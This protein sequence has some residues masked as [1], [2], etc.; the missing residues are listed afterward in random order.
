MKPLRRLAPTLLAA[1]PLLA[2]AAPP[3]A[4]TTAPPARVAALLARPEQVQ[5][6]PVPAGTPPVRFVT[7]RDANPESPSQGLELCALQVPPGA[8]GFE[9]ESVRQEGR[10]TE[11]FAQRARPG[12][13]GLINGGFFGVDRQGALMPLGLLKADGRVLQRR[14]PWAS[15]GVLHDGAG[16][17]AISPVARF[18]DSPG[19]RHAIQSK[20]ML[21]Q[22]GGDGIRQGAPERFDRSAVAITDRGALWLLVAHEP[23]GR[24]LSLNEFS[25][26]LLRL[27]G[28]GGERIVDALAMDG[29]PGAHLHVPALQRDCGSGVPNYVPNLVRVRR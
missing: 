19:I 29:G 8:G 14:H 10:P 6:L 1:V 7:W 2:L 16:P 13:L 17:P 21:V 22:A 9:T 20:P 28:P 3:P 25:A 15:G 5:L 27:R 11:L 12:D 4:A 18:T 26:L 23:G 24:A